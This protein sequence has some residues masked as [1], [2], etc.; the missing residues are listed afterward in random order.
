MRPSGRRR[1]NANVCISGAAGVR[2]RYAVSAARGL[3]N[4]H[5]SSVNAAGVREGL[6]Q[7]M[8]GIIK[9]W[10]GTGGNRRS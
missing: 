1:C 5:L 2:V 7:P 8:N 10:R 3:T 9:R 4:D 6:T